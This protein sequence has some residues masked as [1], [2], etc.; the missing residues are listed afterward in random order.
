MKERETWLDFIKIVACFLVVMLHTI[1]YGLSEN[2]ITPSLLVYYIGTFAIPLFFMVNGYLQL[3]RKVSYKYVIKK[4]IKIVVIVFFWN[5]IIILLKYAINGEIE[6]PI[7][8]TINSFIQRGNFTQFWFLGSLILIYFILP[9]LCRIFNDTKKIYKY[10]VLFLFLICIFMNIFNIYNH[11]NGNEII[12]DT[13]IQ[14]FRLWTW[15]FYFCIGGLLSKSNILEKIPK[16]LHIILSL[17]LCLITVIFFYKF[18]LIFYGSLYAENFYDSFLVIVSSIFIF[19]AIKRIN[20]KQNEMVTKLSSLSM[21]IYIVHTYVIKIVRNFIPISS[22]I[23]ISVFT[24]LVVFGISGILSY[25]VSKIPKI[26]N[27]IKL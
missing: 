10:F 14:T 18:S 21:G 3:R 1:S 24:L 19:T 15:L 4:I 23:L 2:V 20:F 25:I 11:H 6:N 12:K 16:K 5:L 7:L 9:L 22:N 26:N 27:L 13:V 17:I 8:A